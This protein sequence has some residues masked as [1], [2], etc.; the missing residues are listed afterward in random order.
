[1][2]LIWYIDFNEEGLLFTP[3][4]EVWGNVRYNLNYCMT[5]YA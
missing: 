5:N 4:N 2:Y 1:M 3:E